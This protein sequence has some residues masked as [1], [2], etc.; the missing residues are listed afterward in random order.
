MLADLEMKASPRR[1]PGATLAVALALFGC[2]EQ[3]QA[4]QH[5]R[6]PEAKRALV[7]V[8]GD[9][10][11]RLRALPGRTGILAEQKRYSLYD[12]ELII[13]DFFQDRRDGFFVDVGCAWPVDANNTYYLE[14][15][16][17]W[18]GIGID[19]LSDYAEGWRTQ[20]P[21]SKFFAYLV[22]DRSDTQEAFFRSPNTGLSSTD[23][24]LARGDLFGEALEP[25]E[26]RVPSITL[27]DLLQR[28]GVTKV[29]LLAMDIEGHELTALRGFDIERFRPEL[30]VVEGQ[31]RAVHRY[32]R[33]HGY[34][35][36][37]RYLPFDRVNRY[38]AAKQAAHR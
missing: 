21:G 14:K 18:T 12:E 9:E 13:R 37:D 38:Y 1:I 33:Q 6:A 32:F 17:G 34:E 3:P 10:Q 4:V 16:L 2:E 15:H 28:E 27:D 31:R 35:L 19:A 11:A 30:V 7:D 5:A 25:E 36:L 24:R 26:I 22:T 23:P 20:R 29:D 8:I